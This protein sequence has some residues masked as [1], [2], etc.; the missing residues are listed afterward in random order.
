MAEILP[1]EEQ[2]AQDASSEGATSEEELPD[3]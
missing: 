3:H 1:E 2:P